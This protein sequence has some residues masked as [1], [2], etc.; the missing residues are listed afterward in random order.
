MLNE[1]NPLLLKIQYL[2]KIYSYSLSSSLNICLMI[3]GLYPFKSQTYD[4]FVLLLTA[5]MP[6]AIHKLQSF[7]SS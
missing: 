7:F 3:F 6:Y 1:V 5:P 4:F 2:K